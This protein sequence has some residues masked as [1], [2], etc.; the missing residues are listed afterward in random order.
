[1]SATETRKAYASD[2]TDAQW[3]IIATMLPSESD[4]G[5]PREVDFREIVNAVMYRTRTG[6][7]WELLPHDLPPKST[8]YEY[9]RKWQRDGR[10]KAVHDALRRKTRQ[11]EGRNPEASAGIVD[12]Q[13]AK[14]SENCDAAGY[15]AGKKINGRKRHLLVDTLGLIIAVVVTL[16]SVQDRDGAKQVFASAADQPRLEKVWADGG[17]RGKLV[18]WTSKNCA[19]NL[20]IVERPSGSKG[21]VLLPRRWVVERTFGWLNR[22]RLLSKE[23][24]TTIQS[25]TADI[26]IAMTS[27][28]LRRITKPP[29]PDHSNEHLLA[30]IL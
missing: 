2:L 27:L 13:S 14:T 23:F 1:M 26:H 12:S 30:H 7:A 15:D 20:E 25:S 24:E 9:Y 18:D 4:A 19:W 16:A 21:F 8:V 3:E 17:Y 11:H 6:C 10:W 28:M 5:R 29:E 22:Y